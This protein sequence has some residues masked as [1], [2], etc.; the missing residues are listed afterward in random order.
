ML[1]LYPLL[2]ALLVFALPAR[3]QFQEE[4]HAPLY[5]D[6]L[7]ETL[8][9]DYAPIETLS[10]SA[11]EDTLYAV[12]DSV[13]VNGQFGTVGIYTDLF[14]PFD[15]NPSCDPSE[16]VFNDGAGLDLEHVWPRSLGA[17]VGLAESDMHHLFP[18]RVAVDTVRAS[19]PFGEIDDAQ[20]TTWYA[21]DQMQ[22]TPPEES[23]RA[24][25]SEL[26]LNERFEPREDKKGD[27]ARALFYFYTMYG[28]HGKNQADDPF[29]QDVKETLLAW[30][31][32]DP[33]T[34]R[35]MFRSLNISRFQKTDQPGIEAINPFVHDSTLARRAF[36]PGPAL[37]VQAETTVDAVF[38]TGTS[39]YTAYDHLQTALDRARGNESIKEIWVARGVYLPTDVRTDIDSPDTLRY[40]SFYLGSDLELYGGFDGIERE[41]EER[42][43]KTNE[44]VLSGDLGIAEDRTDNAYHVVQALDLRYRATL[45]GFT[46]RDGYANGEIPEGGGLLI[47]ESSVTLRNTR[48]IDNWAN[49]QFGGVGGGLHAEKSEIEL[50]SVTVVGNYAVTR[51]GGISVCC[52]SDLRI[53]DT[54]FEDNSAIGPSYIRGGGLHVGESTALLTRVRF[55]G[56]RVSGLDRS[57]G[58]G[59]ACGVG[60]TCSVVTSDFVRNSTSG[61][62][63]GG[64]LS[65]EGDGSV[66]NSR[67]VGNEAV[68]GGAISTESDLRVTN[69]VIVGNRTIPQTQGD[70]AITGGSVLYIHDGTAALTN[71]TVASNAIPV[72]SETGAI[73]MANT[74]DV[75]LGRNSIFW[76]NGSVVIASDGSGL[77]TL[78][79]TLVEG[80]YQGT[81]MLDADPLFAHAP[82]PGGDGAWGTEDDDYGDLR[83]QEG[84]PAVDFGSASHLPADVFDLD[85]D[86][87][88]DE[89][90]PFD[91]GG[92]ARV[93]GNAP[94]LGAYESPFAVAG[95]PAAG[96][97][98]VDGFSPAYPNPARTHATLDLSLAHAREAVIVEVFDLLG[99]RVA[100]LHDGPLSAGTH[101]FTFD[102]TEL[103]AGVYV[104]QS[105][106]AGLSKARRIVLLR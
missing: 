73:R 36:F 42:D 11:S 71:V 30:H 72:N 79:R 98:L 24:A 47:E 22:S 62:A 94:D 19:L 95:E 90:L 100:L 37:F 20:T 89:R 51:G 8:V 87:N 54:V 68:A 101:R 96:V 39:W 14:V 92:S 15:C 35:E 28:P 84:S 3:A 66:T 34:S 104:V 44:T 58:G 102:S 106:A 4:I 41:R 25:W 5:G 99:R 103:P 52:G 29:F 82:S 18:V 78:D 53:S 32:G 12:I 55:E 9:I 59:L 86:D 7:L 17:G 46:I 74:A 38:Q 13:T 91:L 65:F 27:I 21:L 23:E 49:G 33:A 1:R 26:L 6:E 10:L 40:A 57:S 97:P 56:N 50:D 70:P 64:A 60:S 81:N 83:L 69:S 75:L 88:T 80:G 77:I 63:F 43:W 93:Q 31:E 61:A 105:T 85:G 45:D 67:I 2:F 76:D 48:I 16:D